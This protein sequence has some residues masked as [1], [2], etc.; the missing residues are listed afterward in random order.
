ISL[1]IEIPDDLPAVRASQP[2]LEQVIVN[3]LLN[4]RDAFRL[5]EHEGDIGSRG[6]RI[7]ARRHAPG[8]VCLVTEDTAGGIEP[9]T[10]PRIF[11]PFFTTRP[12]GVGAGV[13]LS[14]SRGIITRF[15]GTMTVGNTNRGARF[16][17][18]LPEWDVEAA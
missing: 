10:L 1:D 6:I 18:T 5:A 2:Q 13:G 16:D 15:G 12:A 4:S 7:A 17:I 8:A 9:A 14:V 3:L 11:D